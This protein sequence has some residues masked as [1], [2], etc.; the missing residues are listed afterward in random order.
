VTNLL[1]VELNLNRSM[2]FLPGDVPGG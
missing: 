1:A 2:I